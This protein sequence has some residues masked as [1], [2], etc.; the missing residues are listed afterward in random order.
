MVVSGP[1]FSTISSREDADAKQKHKQKDKIISHT[2]HEDYFQIGQC[3][4][5][6]MNLL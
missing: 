4:C 3:T 1:I 2:S 5:W 6:Y